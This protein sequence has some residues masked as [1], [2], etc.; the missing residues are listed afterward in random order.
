[1]DNI[2]PLV[3]DFYPIIFR[4]GHWE[5]YE[6]AMLRIWSIFFRYRRK[7]YNKLPLA[8]LSDVFYWENTK[9]PIAETLKTSF[10]IVND[11]Y[12][13]N[14]HS[15]IRNQTNSFNTV[16]QIIYQA[17]MID[18]TRGK[19]SFTETFS[20]DHN[21]VYTEKQ[22]KFLEKKTAIF[23]LDLFQNVWKNLGGVTKKKVR[24]YWQYNLPTLNTIV[25][26]KV[27]PMAWNSSHRPRSD[28]ICDW[29]MCTLSSE[30]SG[31]ILSC[32]HGYH[33]EC[34]IQVNQKCPYCYEYLCDGIRYHCK[35]FQNML[36]KP[37]DDDVDEDDEDLENQ[38]DLQEDNGD[39]EIIS[40]DDDIDK[41]LE[42][43]L[44]ELLNID[45]VVD[46]GPWVVIETM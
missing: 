29:D 38:K 25:D 34:L 8:F 19:N 14:F 41:K 20:N 15:S 30:V 26:Q 37:F 22:L 27:L 39:D 40:L 44:K 24:K 33:M 46:L 31:K 35:V 18:Q 2:I 16:Q 9:H 43:A 42:V 45:Q 5:A 13:E 28:R 12:V 3:L 10:H 36:S 7:N 17:K 1:M 21:I 11:Y 32:G 6:E 4:S 23:L